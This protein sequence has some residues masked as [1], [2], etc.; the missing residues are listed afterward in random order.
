MDGTIVFQGMFFRISIECVVRV[1]RLS[2][3]ESGISV[4]VTRGSSL[5][6]LVFSSVCVRAESQAR[7][8][9]GP[10]QME[11]VSTTS[12]RAQYPC[13]RRLRVHGVHHRA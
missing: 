8:R 5:R 9:E 1:A 4:S 11:W 10:V 2:D 3:R 7:R 13:G 12:H 6:D